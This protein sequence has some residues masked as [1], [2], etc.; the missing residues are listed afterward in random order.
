MV[1][2]YKD[3]KYIL[4]KGSGASYNAG[5]D[6]ANGEL[7][8]FLDYDDF[9]KKNKLTVSEIVYYFFLLVVLRN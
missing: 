1:Q 2:S 8:T 5:I 4:G 3:I 9:W 7:I 6:A